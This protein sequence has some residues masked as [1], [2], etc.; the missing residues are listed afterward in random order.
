MR[1]RGPP[2]EADAAKA[3]RWAA[4]GEQLAILDAVAQQGLIALVKI[5]GLRPQELRY[6]VVVSGELLGGES[7][8]SDG[9]DPGTLL[10][11]ALDFCRQRLPSSGEP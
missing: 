8:R 7:F 2:A 9:G 1:R 3:T 6:T 11:E 5:D 10:R 4:C